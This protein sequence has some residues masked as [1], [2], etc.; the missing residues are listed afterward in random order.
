MALSPCRLEEHMTATCADS[1]V[2]KFHL[3]TAD[4]GLERMLKGLWP[5]SQAEWQTFSEGRK[6]V[7]KLLLEPPELFLIDNRIPDISGIELARLV[8]GENVY[9]QIPVVLLLA[10]AEAFE[11]VDFR[12][13]EI[14][15]FLVLPCEAELARL[16]IMLALQRGKRSFDAN[17]LTRLPG[18]TSIIRRIQRGI[19]CGEEFAVGYVDLDF[20]KSFNDRYGFSRGDEVLMMTSR[21]LV[22]SVRGA[23]AK[24]SFLGHVGGDDFVFITP[25]T[26]AEATCRSIVSSFDAIIPSFYDEKDRLAGGIRS[27]DRSGNER[28]YPIMTVSIGVTHNLGGRLKHYGQASAAASALKTLAK[29]NG[30]SG[31]V[32]DRRAYP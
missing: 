18:N 7:E 23:P 1:W 26:Y 17:P 31:Y 25:C 13:L 22:N 30:K 15:D 14:D 27:K 5:G 9:R 28:D 16:R 32:V 21:L 20:F 8:K 3:I 29:Q 2:G 12:E 4:A 24:Q 19:E 11:G 10:R 6:S